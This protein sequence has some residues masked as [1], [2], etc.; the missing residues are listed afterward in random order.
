MNK[1][2]TIKINIANFA[3]QFVSMAGTQWRKVRVNRKK[4]MTNKKSEI[5]NIGFYELSIVVR[6]Y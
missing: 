3:F 5:I 4:T 6:N 1:G 2:R